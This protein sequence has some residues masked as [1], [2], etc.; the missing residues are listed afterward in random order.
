MGIRKEYSEDNQCDMYKA[1]YRVKLPSGKYK[2]I[3]KFFHTKAGAERAIRRDKVAA[4]NGEYASRS[5]ITLKD[6][7]DR[8][9]KYAKAHRKGTTIEGYE[10]TLGIFNSVIGEGRKVESID[11]NELRK[12]VEHLKSEKRADS[13]IQA[14]L[15]RVI[16]ALNLAPHIF[17]E[18]NTWQPPRYRF[19]GYIKPRERVL[20][21]AEVEAILK[22]LKGEYRDIILCALN[23]G[24]RRSEIL[25]LR[26]DCIYWNAPGYD[27]GA[28]KLKVTKVKGIKET[29]RIIPATAEIIEILKRRK[30]QGIQSPYVFPS[31]L[32]KNKPRKSMRYMLQNAC[33]DA[34]IVYGRDVQGGFVFHDLRRT[35]VTY[36]RRAGVEIETVC[37]ITGHSPNVMLKVYSKSNIE[38]QQKAV[39]ALASFLPFGQFMDTGQKSENENLTTTHDNQST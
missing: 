25:S 27:H 22:N 16:A 3:R 21:F 35:S 10:I 36:L 29:W 9:V 20:E 32:D 1:D 17:E 37:A 26:W 8:V 28:L 18:L 13:T 39:D 33:E 11:R 2:R 38:S 30:E 7:K 34:Q 12:F 4:E 15:A 23:T 14:Y 19:E 5:K 6:L 24:G 31:P